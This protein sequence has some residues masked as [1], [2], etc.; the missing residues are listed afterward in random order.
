M[1]E[2]VTT[3]LM[4]ILFIA[5]MVYYNTGDRHDDDPM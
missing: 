3:V 5:S 2:K 1:V 4:T